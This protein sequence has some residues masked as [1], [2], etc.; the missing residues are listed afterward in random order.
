MEEMAKK[1]INDNKTLFGEVLDWLADYYG[2][3]ITNLWGL[4]VY[5]VGSYAIDH[6]LQDELIEKRQLK[7][8]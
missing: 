2:E 6:L 1:S 3:K 8:E 5:T 4:A 7:S